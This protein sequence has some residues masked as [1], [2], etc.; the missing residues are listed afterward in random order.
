MA[1]KRSTSKRTLSETPLGLVAD[2]IFAP[3]LALAPYCALAV[4]VN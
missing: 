2:P 3:R 1:R 4:M